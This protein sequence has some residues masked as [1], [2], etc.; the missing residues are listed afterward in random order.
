MIKKLSLI[1]IGLLITTS[2]QAAVTWQK[3]N[4]FS[5]NGGL[6]N[7]LSPTEIADNEAT[8][9]QNVVFDTGGAISKRY[10]YGIVPSDAAYT[11]SGG[12]N[13]V[14]TGVYVYRK[15][16]GNRYLVATGSVNNASAAIS[17]K[18]YSL[19]GGIPAGPYTDIT[20]SGTV[21][22]TGYTNNSFTSFTVASNTLVMALPDSV[23]QKP[24][25]WSGSGVVTALT[26]DTRAPTC[27]IVVY[28]KNQLFTNDTINTSRVHFSDLTNGITVW[29]LINF[30]DVNVNDGQSVRGL[31][32]AFNALY[33]FKDRSIWCLTGDNIDNF[34]LQLLVSDVGTM[35]QQ[36]LSV[37]GNFIYFTTAQGDVAVYD[38]TYNV[39]YPSSKIRGTIGG[40]NFSRANQMLTI[41]FSTYKYANYDLY[42][43]GS[44]A[45]SSTNDTVLFFDTEKKAWSVF[46]GWSPNAWC[47]GDNAVGQNILI[48]GDYGGYLYYYPTT[49]SSDVTNTQ[50]AADTNSKLLL[51]L[52]NNVTDSAGGKTVTPT[53]LTY[54]STT[55][56]YKWGLSGAFDGATTFLS[57][58]HSTD[59]DFAGNFTIDCWV[60]IPSV[61]TTYYVCGD[62]NWN[63][64]SDG[65]CLVFNS[66]GNIDFAAMYSSGWTIRLNVAH[67]MS[68]NTL[69][70][71]AIVRNGTAVTAYVNGNSVGTVANSPVTNIT[72]ASS[73]FQVGKCVS[74]TALFF[75]GYIDELRV[76]NTA[77]WTTNF[78]VPTAPYGISTTANT[79]IN[80]YYQTKWWKYQD[81][82]LAYKYWRVV[83]TYVLSQT[84]GCTL[85]MNC[86]N[87]Y[88]LGKQFA[89]TL[90]QSLALWDTAIWDQSLWGGQSLIVDRQEVELGTQMFRLKYSNN[91]VGEGF[92]IFGFINYVEPTDQ[93]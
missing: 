62:S 2:C 81:L 63:A 37:I 50:P 71:I 35:S 76:S 5:N 8:D 10:G 93:V 16:D 53:G 84:N 79:A 45:A 86:D 24:F 67:G 73:A 46:G 56:Q 38:G 34:T 4:Y 28:Y 42:V 59:F 75:S 7:T 18:T 14:V 12:T 20:G 19:G 61:S 39:V 49:T 70:H 25:M 15:N 32:A 47:V 68:I 77:R 6:N 54:S 40:L 13:C 55:G 48:W 87:D 66:A 21:P 80:A 22:T 65:W 90:G 74:G 1:I 57:V 82:S 89:I 58:A 69:Y 29:P 44:S 78:T 17:Y 26:A 88:Q 11:I 9:L 91:N 72:A 51:H 3:F 60:N 31:V 36:S 64:G 23:G 92:T 52:D 85:L 41:P 43:S 27:S 83:T 30:I 33:I